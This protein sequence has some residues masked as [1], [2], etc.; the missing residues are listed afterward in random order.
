MRCSLPALLLL[1]CSISPI[2]AQHTQ[3]P[4]LNA[5]V[6]QTWNVLREYSQPSFTLEAN[7]TVC[8]GIITLNSPTPLRLTSFKLEW[9]GPH[10]SRIY[11][12][13]YHERKHADFAAMHTNLVCDGSWNEEHQH[14]IFPVKD[15]VVA[16]KRY[17][18]VLGTKNG[19]EAILKSGKF[20]L[21]TAT[22]TLPNKTNY[23]HVV[24]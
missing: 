2:Y 21:T 9:Q 16:R 8:V 15:K 11:T 1:G 5:H 14:I 22:S 12:S 10:I 6:T 20:K 7:K 17:Y 24:S 23:S 3:P 13:L 18:L 19:D 4:P